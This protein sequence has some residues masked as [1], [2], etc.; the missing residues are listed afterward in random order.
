MKVATQYILAVLVV[1]SSQVSAAT[2]D[3]VRYAD[4]TASNPENNERGYSN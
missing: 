1:V 2:F 3:F 4:G